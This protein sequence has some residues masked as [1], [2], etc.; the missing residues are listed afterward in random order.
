LKK[1]AAAIC[2]SLF[3]GL[4]GSPADAYTAVHPCPPGSATEYPE[5]GR[6]SVCFPNTGPISDSNPPPG[7]EPPAPA[8]S[9]EAVPTPEAPPD[10]A[11][12][13][14]PAATPPQAIKAWTDLAALARQIMGWLA[15]IFLIF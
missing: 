2:L 12:P 3:I 4:A 15:Q 9:P 6:D 14:T 7:E 11:L 1:S 13:T 8:D 10:Q 5:P